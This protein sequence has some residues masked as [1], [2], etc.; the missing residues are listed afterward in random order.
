MLPSFARGDRVKEGPCQPYPLQ[1]SF[2][3]NMISVSPRSA[4]LGPVLMAL[5]G[6]AAKPSKPDPTMSASN[7]ASN[8][9]LAPWTG[10][11]GGVPPFGRFKVSDLKPALQTAMDD[12]LAEIDR[13]AANPATPTF[14]N[15]IAQMERSGQELD[16]VTAVYVIYT[17]TM[18]DSEVQAIEKEM[19]P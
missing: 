5:L 1:T 10:P 13:I 11:W 8:P 7:D 4:M 3:G 18:N 12:K 16:R 15:T 17:G 6:C 2:G 19:E 14:D 9:L